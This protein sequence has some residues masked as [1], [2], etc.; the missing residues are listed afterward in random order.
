MIALL[1]SIY[2]Q[3]PGV[4]VEH[5]LMV[6]NATPNPV[7]ATELLTGLYQMPELDLDQKRQYKSHYA[8]IV[9]T[10]IGFDPVS[11]NPVKIAGTQRK[12]YWF[13]NQEV[14]E[15]YAANGYTYNSGMTSTE[16]EVNTIQAFYDEPKTEDISI[17]AWL[18]LPIVLPEPTPA[19]PEDI[20]YELHPERRPSGVSLATLSHLFNVEIEDLAEQLSHCNRPELLARE[21]GGQG[22]IL[23]DEE[24]MILRDIHFGDRDSHGNRLV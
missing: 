17:E 13:P 15:K 19:V 8:D 23:T 18:A 1:N 6:A 14:A 12:W 24:L 3:T 10:I 16:T 20:D 2:G 22:Y 21:D 9:A 7:A 11:A 5:L 4:S